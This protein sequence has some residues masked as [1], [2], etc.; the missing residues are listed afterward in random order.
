MPEVSIRSDKHD[1]VHST[2]GLQKQGSVI[3]AVPTEAYGLQ[4][5]HIS[6]TNAAGAA[7]LRL[8]R[9]TAKN[10][11]GDANSTH[12]SRASSLEAASS[13]QQRRMERK[14][15][16]VESLHPEPESSKTAPTPVH[17]PKKIDHTGQRHGTEREGRSGKSSE[18]EGRS[19]KPRRP[20]AERRRADELLLW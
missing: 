9:K 2:W 10:W 5:Y 19:G 20:L 18:R 6:A 7:T 1:R 13:K 16:S 11:Q 4:L 15:A 17:H 14:S 8:A 12:V 3:R